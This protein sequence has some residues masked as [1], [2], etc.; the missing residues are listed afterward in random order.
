MYHA[1]WAWAGSTPY[2]GTKLVAAYFGGTRQPMAVSWP[3]V[4]KHDD[5]P[6]S[7]FLHVND[8]VPTIYDVLKI[9]PPQVVNG[10]PQG[11]I[12]GI[13]FANTFADPKAKVNKP[14]QFFD[15]MGSRGIY[16]DG[17]FACAFGLRIPWVPGLPKGAKEWTP[18]KDQWELYNLDEDWTQA[19]DLAAKMPEKLAQ[20]KGLFLVESAKNL[21]LPIGGGLWTVVFHPEDAPSTP[22]TEWTFRGPIE[23][24]PEFAAPKLGN[25]SNVVSMEVDLKE[26]ANGVLYALGAFSGGLTCYIK[27]GVLCY[28]YNLFEID[29]TQIKAKDKLPA[30]KAKIEVESKLAGPKPGGPMEVTLKVNGKTAASGKVPITAPVCFTANDCLDFGSDLGS[31]VSLDYFDEAPFKLNGTLGTSTVKYTK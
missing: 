28:E 19:N 30:G 12:D 20:M 21:N 13:S 18:E 26:N 31:P 16:H 3:K 7:Q 14:T 17:W 27:D 10:V 6:R 2:K 11:P 8:I 9:T 15:V 5:T 4:I 29:R 23:R 25:R 24:M 1:G 22:Y